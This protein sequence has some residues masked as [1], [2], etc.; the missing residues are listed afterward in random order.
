M[1]WT[2]RRS[3][4]TSPAVARVLGLHARSG[5]EHGA[6]V[7]HPHHI[8][9]A[10]AH[11]ALAGAAHHARAAVHHGSHHA[12]T[13]HRA[14]AAVHH[15]GPHHALTAAHHARA[16]HHSR[17]GRLRPGRGFRDRGSSRGRRILR[18]ASRR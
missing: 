5:D 13:A 1:T 11:H 18:T 8:H 15:A 14:L 3:S 6:L 2:R 12:L 17:T 4:A 9:H 10:A 7:A 16:P